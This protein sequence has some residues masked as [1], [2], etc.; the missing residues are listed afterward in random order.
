ME[1]ETNLSKDSSAYNT[2]D[3]AIT[4]VPLEN[5]KSSLNIAVTSAAWI[6]SLST[7]VTGGALIEG[8]NFNSALLA[9]IFGMLILGIYGFFQGWMGGKYG[10]STT[11]LARQAFGRYGAG[12]FGVVLAVT[13]GIGWFGWQV[14]FLELRLLRCSLMLGWQIR[15]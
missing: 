11:V 4:S 2:D 14:A 13:M 1:L 5:R 12:L 8:L 6:I 3:Y 9:G 15:R 7:I 10:I